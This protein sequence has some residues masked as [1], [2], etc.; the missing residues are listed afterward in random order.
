MACPRCVQAYIV[1]RCEQ[2]CVEAVSK[3]ASSVEPA[4]RVRWSTLMLMIQ[5]IESLQVYF[6]LNTITNCKNVIS[7]IDNVLKNFD[8]AEAAY[9]VTYR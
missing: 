9:R 1:L 7:T 4:A 6:R 3:L 2:A 8:S 5:M